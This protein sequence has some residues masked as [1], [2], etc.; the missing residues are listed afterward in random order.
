MIKKFSN[1][2]NKEEVFLTITLGYKKFKAQ[3]YGSNKKIKNAN[4]K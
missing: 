2:E 4:K 1:I 3:F